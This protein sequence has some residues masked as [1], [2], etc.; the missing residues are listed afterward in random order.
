MTTRLCTTLLTVF[1]LAFGIHS[2][3]CQQTDTSSYFPLGVW[4]I[5]ID[6]EN[7]PYT[8][9]IT[10]DEWD[11]EHTNWANLHGNYLV[12][13]IPVQVE[14]EVM[15]FSDNNGYRMD[16]AG[17]DKSDPASYANSLEGWVRFSN[18]ADTNT[19]I[20]LINNLWT[21][22]Q[23]HQG[24]YNYTF[25]SEFTVS[26]DSGRPA[27]DRWPLV[28]FVSERIRQTDPQRKSVTDA[29]HSWNTGEFLNACPSLDVL[30]M[31]AY[32]FQTGD[33]KEY[34]DQQ[35]DFDD[36]LI[37]YNNIMNNTRG[38]WTEWQ[39]I[40]QSQQEP[41]N[42]LRRPNYYEVRAQAFLA[43]SRGARGVTFYVYGTHIADG[44]PPGM[45]SR[46]TG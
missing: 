2:V 32:F 17:Y 33:G 31:D 37:H 12:Y 20:A 21:Q 40:G 27:V 34:D 29:A 10:V 11:R 16:I 24:W 30:R 36:C 26:D 8:R 5:W 19:A 42:G 25:G 22:W 4:G 39:L 45:S 7:P 18:M 1:S 43:L 23:V 41:N 3:F 46:D 13:F 6:Y 44:N 38:K 35:S 14:D 15:Q 28:Q 9:D